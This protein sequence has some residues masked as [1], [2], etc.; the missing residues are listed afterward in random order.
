MNVVVQNESHFPQV[1]LLDFHSKLNVNI[2]HYGY[3]N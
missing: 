1:K 2:K 3:F